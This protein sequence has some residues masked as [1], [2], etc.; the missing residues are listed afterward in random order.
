MQ[1]VPFVFAL[2]CALALCGCWEGIGREVLATVLST[3]GKVV[4]FSKGS[5]NF[6]PVTSRTNLSAGSSLRTS[7]EAQINLMLVPGALAQISADSE[8]N[9][10]E[11]TLTKDGNETGDAMHERIARIELRRGGIVVLFEGAAR[12]TIATR[13]AT[14]NVLPS[15][16]LR[17]DVDEGGTRA[18]CVRGKF[19]ATPQNGQIVAVDAGYFRE[20]PSERGAVSTA[21]DRRGQTDTTATLE[22]ARELQELAVAQRDRLP[23]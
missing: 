22:T 19:Y 2:I 12:F 11:L 23:F 18:T 14:I 13:A 3:R 17:L 16:L 1:R 8:L 15:C 7:S 20:W 6:R 10:E 5:P 4:S 9:I 21:E